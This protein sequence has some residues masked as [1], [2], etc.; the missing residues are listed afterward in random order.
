MRSIAQPLHFAKGRQRILHFNVTEHPNGPWIVQQLRE[1]IGESCLYRYLILDCDAK[2][3]LEL[4]DFLTASAVKPKRISPA[5]PWQNGIAERWVGTCRREL[6]DH[7]IVINEAHLRRRIREYVS[8]YHADRIHE[9]LEKDT[10]KMRPVSFKP[11]ESAHVVSFPRL[12][13]LH[14]RYDWGQAA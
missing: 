11:N 9:S 1:S 4:T 7:L 3:G 6:L 12:G 10:P 5:S 8:Y 14:H 13:G 2:Y